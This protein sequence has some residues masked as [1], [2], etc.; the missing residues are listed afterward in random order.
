MNIQL[1]QPVIILILILV[2]PRAACLAGPDVLVLDGIRIDY[3]ETA[4]EGF[5]SVCDYDIKRLDTSELSQASIIKYINENRP[6]VIYVRGNQ[7]LRKILGIADIPVVYSLVINPGEFIGDRANFTGVGLRIPAEI[8]YEILRI[9][10]PEAE[11]VGMITSGRTNDMK[12]VRQAAKKFGFKIIERR[13]Y[14]LEN[15]PNLLKALGNKIDLFSMAPDSNVFKERT[16]DLLMDY[17]RERAIPVITYNETFLDMGAFL[18]IHPKTRRLG[19]QAAK[20]SNRILKGVDAPL[21]PPEAPMDIFV[22]INL[23]T[24]R[25][26]GLIISNDLYM[27]T[28]KGYKGSRVK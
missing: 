1:K 9:A 18:S 28:K 5:E 26:L 20:M 13:L 15:F 10:M 19:S 8:K 6:G 25:R 17:C 27:L 4:L 24:A 3:F 21:P 2:L 7:I 14:D 11:R 16:V 22:K 23:K 12:Q